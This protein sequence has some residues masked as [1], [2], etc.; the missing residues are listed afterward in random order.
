VPIEAPIRTNPPTTATTESSDA[1]SPVS[2]QPSIPRA[3]PPTSTGTRP[4]RSIA[5]PAGKAARAAVP[6]NIAGPKPTSPSKPVTA[7]K[8]MVATATESWVIP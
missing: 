3:K 8:M 6:K 2:R 4:K 1:P 5:C 7:T